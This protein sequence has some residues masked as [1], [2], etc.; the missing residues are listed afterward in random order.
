MGAQ[1]VELNMGEHVQR[2][3]SPAL[4]YLGPHMTHMFHPN[5]MEVVEAFLRHELEV[6]PEEPHVWR[7]SGDEQSCAGS[8]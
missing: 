8:S 5:F 6:N 1:F 3:R 2:L 7:M 4:R